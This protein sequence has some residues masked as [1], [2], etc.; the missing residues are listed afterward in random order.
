LYILFLKKLSFKKLLNTCRVYASYYLSV[1]FKYSKRRGYPLSISV[2]PTTTC[3]LQCPE[4]PSGNGELTRFRGD[5]DLSLFKKITDEFAPYL[6]NLILYFQGEPFLNKEIFKLFEY[7]SVT[8][9]IFTTTSTNG[10]YLN[11]ENAEKTVKSGLDKIII[12]IDGTTQDIYEQYRKNG[13]L[14]TIIKGINNLVYWRKKLQ[15]STPYIVIQFIVFRFNEHQINDIKKL[16]K[17]LKA[18]KLELKSA[19]IY[20]FTKNSHLIPTNSKYSRYKRNTDGNYEIKSRLKNRCKRL[21]E[22]TVITN[23]GDVLPCCFDKDAQY[24]SGNLKDKDFAE[25]N[26]NETIISFRRKLLKNR[27]QIDICRNC[28]E[29]LYNTK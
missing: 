29:G 9:K 3:N 12:S 16:S 2:E 20:D 7:A 5:I 11:S 1:F 26:N 23:T 22:S 8:K 6:L 10:H 17:E 19:Q 24:I 25:I 4:C 21:W 13:Q 18:D 27:K 15:Y 14:N 28:T